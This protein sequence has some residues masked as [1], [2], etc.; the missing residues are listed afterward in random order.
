MKVKVTE[1][2]GGESRTAT[3]ETFDVAETIGPWFPGRPIEVSEAIHR[4]ERELK[5][6]NWADA[7]S[8]AEFLGLSVEPA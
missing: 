8:L 6:G 4:L 3:V 2:I 7:N 5:A 1:L